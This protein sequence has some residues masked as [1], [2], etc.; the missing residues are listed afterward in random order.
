[1]YLWESTTYA[2]SVVLYGVLAFGSHTCLVMQTVIDWVFG[3]MIK[4]RTTVSL[5]GSNTLLFNIQ[6]FCSQFI[7]ELSPTNYKT[8]YFV[9]NDRYSKINPSFSEF[10]NTIPIILKNFS[11][12]WLSVFQLIFD[13]LSLLF[14]MRWPC[15]LQLAHH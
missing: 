10:H 12:V 5:F 7:V 15:S 9:L 8:L 6:Y 11:D 4:R 1:M 13:F 2:S 3:L 14:V